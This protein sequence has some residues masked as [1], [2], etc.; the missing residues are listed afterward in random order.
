MSNVGQVGLSYQQKVRDGQLLLLSIGFFSV[1]F[2]SN[3]ISIC[4]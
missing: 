2:N 4:F 3:L 1:L